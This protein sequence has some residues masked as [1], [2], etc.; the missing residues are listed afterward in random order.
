MLLTQHHFHLKNSTDMHLPFSIKSSERKRR[1]CSKK[2]LLKGLNTQTPADFKDFL[3]NG[4][5][6]AQLFDLIKTVWSNNDMADRLVGKIRIMINQGKAYKISSQDGKSISV[7][8]LTELH[9]NQEETDCRQVLYLFY[10][11]K[12]NFKYAVVRTSDSDPLFILLYFASK[13]QPLVIHLDS[14]SGA[15]R[16]QINVT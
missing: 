6:K 10:A 3:T 14:G 16:R 11:K 13:L 4:D 7:E 5:N 9:S 12:N 15:H 1:G 2:L 8:E